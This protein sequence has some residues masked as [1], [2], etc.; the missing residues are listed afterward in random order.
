MSRP[1]VL[2][3]APDAGEYPPLLSGL[4][5]EGTPL[6]LATG[7]DDARAAWA[8]QPIVPGQPDLVAAALDVFRREPLPA[9]SPLWEA[10]GV[11]VTAHVAA[12][13]RSPDIARLFEANYNLYLA[14]SELLYGIDFEKGY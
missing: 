14:G 4:S 13:S 10:P 3:L 9:D 12:S 2:I 8:G 11:T 5:R 1:S 7:P 6:T